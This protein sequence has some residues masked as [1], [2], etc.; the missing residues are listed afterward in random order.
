MSNISRAARRAGSASQRGAA[1]LEYTG[2]IVVVVAIVA[3]VV[4]AATPV[5]GTIAAKLC[6]AFGASCGTTSQQAVAPQD[7][8]FLPPACMYHEESE[9]YSSEVSIGFVTIGNNSGFIVSRFRDGRVEVTVTDGA[10][11]GAKGEAPGA[12]FDVGKLGQGDNAGVDVDFGGGLTFGYGDTWS[13]DDEDQYEA[14][15]SDLDD[16]LLQQEMMKQGGGPG[17]GLGTHMAIKSMGGYKD[18]PKDPSVTFSQFGVEGSFNAS[19][20]LR[21]PTGTVDDNGDEKFLDPNAGVNLNVKAGGQGIRKVDTATGDVSWTYELTGEGAVG[22]EL[23]A[24]GGSAQGKTQGAFT[25]T[26]DASGQVV[27]LE[28]KSLREGG[29]EGHL[30]NKKTFESGGGA[31][32]TGE[33]NQTVVTTAL[34]VDASNRDVVDAWLSERSSVG[35]AAALTLPWNAMVPDAPSDDPFQQEMY[36]NAT[37]SE[38]AYH[39][40]KDVQGFDL[41]VKAGWKFGFGLS[42]EEATADAVDAQFLGAPGPDGR[43]VMIDDATCVE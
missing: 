7:E 40:I 16:Y 42:M 35:E 39:N 30:G 5:G 8:D 12:T 43:R 27:G 3:A 37:T 1:T 24:G 26:R 15:R 19:L 32:G 36:E 25:V 17:S 20:G 6:E 41:A 33:S 4:L 18:P 31:A 21:E 13:F 14:M 10:G 22:A 11:L 23:V 34:E 2:V 38:V 28:F 9:Q 29:V